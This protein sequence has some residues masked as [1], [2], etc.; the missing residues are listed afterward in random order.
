MVTTGLKEPSLLE[1]RLRN[2]GL[3]CLEQK[4]L[5]GAG[6][7]HQGLKIAEGRVQRGQSQTLSVGL[8][9]RMTKQRQQEQSGAQEAP[10]ECQEAPLCCAGD[11]AWAQAAQRGCGLSFL[12]IHLDKD[13]GPLS[14]SLPGQGSDQ[15]A[16]RSTFQPQP[17]RDAVKTSSLSKRNRTDH[18]RRSIKLTS[19]KTSFI[20]NKY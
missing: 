19:R 4:R 16:S 9:A 5:K 3:F 2:L 7:T 17:P 11:G 12:K 13:L 20:Y 1:E 10:S 15:V 14:V 8:S 18:I 6:L